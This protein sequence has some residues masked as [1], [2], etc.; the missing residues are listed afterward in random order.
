M[1]IQTKNKY[2][3]QQWFITVDEHNLLNRSHRREIITN[4]FF[5]LRTDIE[6]FGILFDTVT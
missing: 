5:V 1:S 2:S 6:K 4:A 3:V